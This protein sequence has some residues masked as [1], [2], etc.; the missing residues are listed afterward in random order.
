[1]RASIF[2]DLDLSGFAPESTSAPTAEKVRAVSE[3]ANFPSRERRQPRVYRTGRNTQFNVK[4]DPAVI[5][6]F[7][8]ISNKKGWVLGKTLEEA[9]K[10]LEEK[11]SH[12][13]K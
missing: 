13:A 2:E 11:L 1:M 7:Y 8:E 4:A 9:L 3:A 5:E 10:A 12:L 6:R